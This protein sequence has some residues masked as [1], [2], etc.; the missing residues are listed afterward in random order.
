MSKIRIGHGVYFDP[1]VQSKQLLPLLECLSY[2]IA[3]NRPVDFFLKGIL[4][5]K[6]G[7]GVGRSGLEHPLDFGS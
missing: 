4:T 6:D 2:A 5:G 3:L 1:S 7:P